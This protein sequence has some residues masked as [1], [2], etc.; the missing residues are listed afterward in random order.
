MAVNEEVNA[1]VS[2]DSFSLTKYLTLDMLGKQFTSSSP[3]FQEWYYFNISTS[4]IVI[5]FIRAP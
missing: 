5:S 1:C 2:L 3:R 4:Q